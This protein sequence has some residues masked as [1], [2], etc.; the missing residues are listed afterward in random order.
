MVFLKSKSKE[1]RYLKADR[2]IAQ[3][4]EKVNWIDLFS[5]YVLFS[6]CWSCDNTLE[7]CSFYYVLFTCI[8][9]R[10]IHETTKVNRS[11]TM[12]GAIHLTKIQTGLTGKSGSPQKV[13]RFFRNFSGWTE[14]IHWVL[15]R[16]F[17]K[18]WLNGSRLLLHVTHYSGQLFVPTLKAI[19]HTTNTYP[20]CDSTLWPLQ[21]SRQNHR[22]HVWTEAL[23][24]MVF[25][26]AHVWTQP[27]TFTGKTK[28]TTSWRNLL[29]TRVL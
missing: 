6:Q 15:D 17:R 19:Q 7:N 2:I 12:L 24:S 4:K 5:L 1:K 18:F 11:K 13:D 23:S 22:S 25:A 28:Q 20:I 29:S 9:A 16:N 3:C 26:P 8:Y 14:P 10:I 27:K 21:K